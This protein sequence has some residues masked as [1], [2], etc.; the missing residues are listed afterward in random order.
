MGASTDD[1][2]AAQAYDET[3]AIDLYMLAFGVQGVPGSKL[4]PVILDTWLSA[5]G[6]GVTTKT[7]TIG[8]KEVTTVDYG[9]QGNKAYVYTTANGVVIVQTADAALAAQAIAAIP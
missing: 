3:G 6:A 1:L 5:T 2:H 9:D 8:G 4:A 7:E